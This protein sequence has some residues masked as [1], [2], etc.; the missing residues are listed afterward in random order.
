MTT[1]WDGLP[2]YLAW[3]HT[4]TA[5]MLRQSPSA[6]GTHLFAHLLAAERGWGERIAG[7]PASCPIWPVWSLPECEGRIAANADIYRQLLSER[8]VPEDVHYRNSLG[9]EF[10]SSRTDIL[11]HVLAHGAYHRGQISQEIRRLDGEVLDTDF[12]LF[13]RL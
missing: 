2:D 10:T 4:R 7:Q 1:L 5:Q 11:L 12:I 8:N 9:E 6:E 3:A 13:K